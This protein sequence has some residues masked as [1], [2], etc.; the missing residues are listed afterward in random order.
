MIVLKQ[1]LYE[2]IVSGYSTGYIKYILSGITD[3]KENDIRM[4]YPSG[5]F[6]DEQSASFDVKNLLTLTRRRS[7]E[8]N[9]H[10]ILKNN[11]KKRTYR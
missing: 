4:I 11:T 1:K 10:I 6:I 8:I 9:N 5:N 2:N 3:N 7:S